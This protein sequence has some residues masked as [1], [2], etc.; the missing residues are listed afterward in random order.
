MFYFES[1]GALVSNDSFSPGVT[2]VT[3]VLYP[4]FLSS[5]KLFKLLETSNGAVTPLNNLLPPASSP[6]LAQVVQFS[7]LNP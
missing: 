4:A 5:D 6:S 3:P 1:T 7:P 2:S